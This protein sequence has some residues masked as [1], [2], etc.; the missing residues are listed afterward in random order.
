VV[1][2]DQDDCGGLQPVG[3]VNWLSY[4]GWTRVVVSTLT[5]S[6][7]FFKRHRS[8]PVQTGYNSAFMGKSVPRSE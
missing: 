3:V 5:I 1:N 2:Q 4:A 7:R 8:T 6:N